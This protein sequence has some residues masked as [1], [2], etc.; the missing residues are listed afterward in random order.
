MKRAVWLKAGTTEVNAL[1][2]DDIIEIQAGYD[3]MKKITKRKI[4]EAAEALELE[5]DEDKVV[6]AKKILT[7]YMTEQ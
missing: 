1:S 2:P 3:G 6:F 4:K 5:Y 7:Y